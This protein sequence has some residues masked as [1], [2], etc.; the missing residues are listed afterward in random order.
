MS[1]CQNINSDKLLNLRCT[2]K[3]A[4]SRQIEASSM[5]KFYE[6]CSERPFVCE[7]FHLQVELF[8]KGS[9]MIKQN[10]ETENLQISCCL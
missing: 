3:G 7:A 4:E 1:I 8:E 10:W 6:L 5:L 2:P 9:Q